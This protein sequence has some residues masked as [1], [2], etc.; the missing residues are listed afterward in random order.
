MLPHDRDPRWPPDPIPA[1]FYAR[2]EAPPWAS[3]ASWA[4]WAG[5]VRGLPP[6]T[7]L[8]AGGVAAA[9]VLLVGVIVGLASRHPA[10]AAQGIAQVGA[11][12]GGQAGATPPG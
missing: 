8:V 2:G 9:G 4:S 12:P 1:S 5:M 7:L 11:S 10:P 6:R 3:W